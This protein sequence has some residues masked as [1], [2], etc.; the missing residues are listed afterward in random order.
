MKYM[1][2]KIRES[3]DVYTSSTVFFSFPKIILNQIDDDDGDADDDDDGDY[4]RS[5]QW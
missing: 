5:A 4:T 3:L 2:S 1:R